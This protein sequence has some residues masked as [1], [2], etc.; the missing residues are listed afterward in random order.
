[1]PTKIEEKTQELCQTLIAQPEMLSI[2]KRID[3]FLA[4]ASTRGQYETLMGKGQALHEKQQHGQPLASAEISDFEKRPRSP[5]EKSC[6]ERFS[7]RAGGASRNPAFDPETDL[8][9][10]GAWPHPDRRR[11]GRR[12]V[13]PRLRLPPLK[14]FNAPPQTRSAH[15]SIAIAQNI[16]CCPQAWMLVFCCDSKCLTQTALIFIYMDKMTSN[17]S[18]NNLPIAPEPT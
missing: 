6:R 18:A 10:A 14:N 15:F 9:N 7:R 4:D 5:A 2:R 12:L 11:F 8:Q 17:M 1:M 13:R 16:D 3:T